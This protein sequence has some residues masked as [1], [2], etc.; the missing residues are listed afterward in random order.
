MGISREIAKLLRRR[1]MKE[2]QR[3]GFAPVNVAM[4]TPELDRV[5]ATLRD[6]E[7][8]AN[9]AWGELEFSI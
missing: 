9:G 2:K 3:D 8:I 1:N 7:L 4:E 5:S 6:L